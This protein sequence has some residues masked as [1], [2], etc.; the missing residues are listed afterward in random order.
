M[1]KH[2]YGILGPFIGRLGPTVGY[3]LG[4]INVSRTIG[5]YHGPRTPKQ[6]A[7]ETKMALVSSL[8]SILEEFLNFGLRAVAG[9][10]KQDPRNYFIKLNKQKAVKGE[11][12][13]LETDFSKLIV[14]DGNIPAPKNGQAK[15]TGNRLELTW[16][17]DMEAEGTNERDQVM[18]LA[19]F[20]SV[21]KAVTLASGARRSAEM[22]S[23]NLPEFELETAVEVY[24][25]FV[26]D[27]R[28]DA[29]PSLYLGQLL[30]NE[31]IG[32]LEEGFKF[33]SEAVDKETGEIHFDPAYQYVWTPPE[34]D[35]KKPEQVHKVKKLSPMLRA[36]KAQI[37][38][39]Y[40]EGG[41]LSQMNKAMSYNLL[42]AMKGEAPL[43][44][45]DFPKLKF[46]RGKRETAWST[47]MALDTENKLKVQ[48][49]VPE[50]ANMKLIGDDLAC[51]MVYNQSR[52]H[53]SA[54][55][56]MVTRKEL[57]DELQLRGIK[58]GDTIHAWVF[59]Y[60]PDGTQASN[61]DYLGSLDIPKK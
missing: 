36:F 54:V 31:G 56:Y 21:K 16:K 20:P 59:F 26:A 47:K 34:D 13:L 39:G 57:S 10:G 41:T 52:K 23:I 61:T 19:Y 51:I 12:P 2:P 6:F 28:L 22:E 43:Y 7:N 48:W 40:P 55:S 1:A 24:M 29:S 5:K 45:I 18:V 58:P 46:S 11:Y 3:M 49:A 17:A 8:S 32:E 33:A 50:T 38:I 53:A 30:L 60:T 35:D 15:L 27:N 37:N 25:A 14:A 44:H 9:T 4:D 42:H